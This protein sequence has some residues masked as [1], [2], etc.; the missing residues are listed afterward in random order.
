MNISG[1][2]KSIQIDNNKVIIN[3]KVVDT[4]K[5]LQIYIT[6]EGDCES[7][8]ADACNEVHI[9]GN[10]TNEVKTMSGDVNCSG[11]IGG[12]VSTMSGDV[13]A[14]SI[15]GNVSTMSGDITRV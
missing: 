3:G 9:K 2:F 4:G 14:K 11:N 7:I 5:D 13:V 10:V 8:Q 15:T 6:A 12:N 1:N